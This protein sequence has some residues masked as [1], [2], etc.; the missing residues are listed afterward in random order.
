DWAWTHAK[1]AGRGSATLPAAL[2]LF[3]PLRTARSPVGVLGVQMMEDADLPSPEQ[4]RLL[5][6]LADQAAIAIERTTLVSDIETARVATER[7]R[8]RSALL[9]SLSHD[10][11][12]PLVSIMGA[13]SSLISYDE[14]LAPAD[15][16]DLAQT[17]Q[18]EAERL[19]RFVQNLLDMTRLGSGTLKPR[20]DWADLSDIVG[21]AVE[22]AARLTRSHAVKV[23]IDPDM[24]LLCVDAILMGQVFFNLIDNA[25]KYSPSGTAIKIWAKRAADH[26]SIEVADQGPGIPEADREKV[27]DMFYRVNLT[28]S[29][30]AG[31]G[32]G[33]AICRGI[34]EAHGGSIRAESGL[35]ESGAA[36]II[37]LPLP[38]ALDMA[39]ETEGP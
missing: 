15:R 34:V 18:D 9:S 6:T 28:D 3:L 19:N 33:L 8:L 14:A 27:F 36:I 29:Q 12:T 10:L 2:W 22:R 32:L 23:E 5:E 39:I 16:K 30:S 26:I 17:I 24:P 31:T 25:C 4:M 20:I 7:E 1:P 11:R 13:A 37:R 21:G 38:P 35:H